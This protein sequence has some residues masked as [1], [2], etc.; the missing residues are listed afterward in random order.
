MKK[1]ININFQ[2]RII[3]IEENA[4]EM[5][6]QY[7]DSLRQYFINEEG[8]EEIIND[9][10]NRIAELFSNTL[11]NGS[12]CIADADVLAVIASIGRPQDFEEHSSTEAYSTNTATA[13]AASPN[14]SY[15]T[16]GTRLVRNS[17]D[18]IIAGVCSGLA[19]SLRIDPVMMRILFVLFFG[20]A[21]W[22][23]VVLWIVLPTQSLKTNIT[24]RLYRN[25]E[26]K[27]IAGVCSGLATYFKVD[28]WITRL[29]FALPLLFSIFDGLF[30]GDSFDFFPNVGF[31]SGSLT[32]T[33][34]FLYIVLWIVLP[35]ATT[36]AEKLELRGEK[37]D[38]NSIRETVKERAHSFTEEVKEAAQQLGSKAKSIAQDTGQ[39]ANSL[40]AETKPALRQT[41]SGI[42]HLISVLVKILLFLIIGSM[43]LG[44]VAALVGLFAA[45]LA[46]MPFKNYLLEN[47][48]QN[49]LAWL[50][51]LLFIG[52]PIL[53]FIVF[54]IRRIAGIKSKNHYLGYAF[55]TL[56]LVGLGCFIALVAGIRSN[57]LYPSKQE[58][59]YVIA[60][61]IQDKLIVKVAKS[62][63]RYYGGWWSSRGF[64]FGISEDSML[65][66]NV[67]LKIAKSEDATYHTIVNKYSYGSTVKQAEAYAKQIL[68]TLNQQDSV[69]YLDYGFTI[70]K[71]EKFRNQQVLIT[72]QVPVGKRILVD[73]SVARKYQGFSL[74][75]NEDGDWD[76]DED[77]NDEWHWSDDVEY[78]MTPGG[79]QRVDELDEKEL[80]NGKFKLKIDENGVDIEAEGALEDKPAYKYR[81]KQIEDSIKTKATEKI[82]EEMRVKDSIEREKK[83]KAITKKS[84]QEAAT[85]EALSSHYTAAGNYVF[86][87]IRLFKF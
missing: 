9:I 43:A 61:N 75:F 44:V 50:S 42:G 8:K 3:P 31:I 84:K 46:L 86:S 4:Y 64:P 10:E 18:K 73:K 70:P 72:V 58:Q 68:F 6:K 81:Y 20:I 36:A 41:A 80:K 27:T 16:T 63:T 65:L 39:T 67:T 15:T 82:R 78:M 33:I 17:D 24:K 45:G 56:W 59:A 5:L 37:I 38:L 83:L 14:A 47:N 32:G 79:L 30:W 25:S 60:N 55:I 74:H 2:G 71:G 57:F 51:L 13:P 48:T 76:D 7:I 54:I 87:A 26:G 49:I 62:S 66:K 28:I 1:M 52:I 23:Y 34:V 85:D 21:F 69:L 19:N 29:I 12:V 40:S 77:D 53:A 22:I 35:E 11:K